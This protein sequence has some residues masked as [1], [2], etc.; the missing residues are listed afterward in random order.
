MAENLTYLEI[1]YKILGEKPGLKQIHYR[2]LANK[3]FEL[4][5]I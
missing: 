1:A 4:G 3:A 2:D 5:L